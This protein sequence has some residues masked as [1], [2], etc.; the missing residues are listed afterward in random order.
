VIISLIGFVIIMT[1]AVKPYLTTKTASLTAPDTTPIIDPAPAITVTLPRSND[2]DPQVFAKWW[3]SLP[4]AN[5]GS[6]PGVDWYDYEQRVARGFGTMGGTLARTVPAGNRTIDTDGADP[7]TCYLLEAKFTNDPNTTQFRINAP[8]WIIEQIS[9]EIE[10][11]HVAIITGAQPQGLV[12]I[13]NHHELRPFFETLL[14]QQ[15]FVIGHDG[16]VQIEY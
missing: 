5:T 2:C 11:Y 10:R 16:F 3:N 9:G 4:L 14:V 13:T 12:I 1:I 7:N 15:G 6:Q 8:P